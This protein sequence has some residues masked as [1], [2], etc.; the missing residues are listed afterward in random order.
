MRLLKEAAS[1]Q[2][3]VPNIFASSWTLFRSLLKSQPPFPEKQRAWGNMNSEGPRVW[4]KILRLY[5]I[6]DPAQFWSELFFVEM[7]RDFQAVAPVHSQ[8]LRRTI[9]GLKIFTTA[10][11]LSLFLC[12]FYVMQLVS[13]GISSYDMVACERYAQCL[14]CFALTCVLVD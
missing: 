2:R 8:Q 5:L 10:A 1:M 3:K 13:F 9:L 14:L 6:L 7:G 4:I 11:F 12:I